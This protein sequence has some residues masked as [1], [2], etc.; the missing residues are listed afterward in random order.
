MRIKM[1]YEEMK[2]LYEMVEALLKLYPAG[3]PAEELIDALV[4]KVR[5]RLRNRLDNL[6]AGYSITLPKEEALAFELWISQMRQVLPSPAY[7]YELN[8]ATQITNEIIDYMDNALKRL[9]WLE[10]EAINDYDYAL[11]ANNQPK[12]IAA[13]KERIRILLLKQTIYRAQSEKLKEDENTEEH[14]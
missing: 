1:K 6:K 14:Y 13:L 10:E 3:D 8:T 9:I 11:K 7:I 2:S 12:Q 5:I 4:N